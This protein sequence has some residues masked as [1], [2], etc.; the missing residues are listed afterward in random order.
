MF[1]WAY[2]NLILIGELTE[3]MSRREKFNF[4]CLNKKIIVNPAYIKFTGIGKFPFVHTP[5]CDYPYSRHPFVS[6]DFKF[7]NPK[8]QHVTESNIDC[9]YGYDPSTGDTIPVYILV[10]CGKCQP[11]IVKKRVS[12]KNQMILEQSV[13]EEPPVF[14]TLTYDDQ[15]LPHDGVSVRDVQ[16]F[17]K[18]FRSYVDYHYPA[19][20]KFRYVC[21]SEYGSLHGRPHYHLLLFGLGLTSPR[22]ILKLETD[23][24]TTW[25]NG[26]VYAKLC[27]YGCFNYVSKY[28]CKGSN[29]PL[30]KNPNFRLSSRR[31]GGIGVPA[32]D[33][34]SLLSQAIRSP[35]PVIKVKCLGKVFDVYIPKS[36]RDSLF[37]SPRQFYSPVAIK[38]YKRFLH[39]SCLLRALYD[40][41][42]DCAA[43]LVSCANINKPYFKNLVYRDAAIIP[44]EIYD[45]FSPLDCSV[46]KIFVPDYMVVDD[47]DR[48]S[49]SHL[50][51]EYENL[52]EYLLNVVIDFDKMFEHRYLRNKIVG[53]WTLSLVQFSERNPDTDPFSISKFNGIIVESQG[54]KD[55]Q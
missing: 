51:L 32:F 4:M 3:Y 8:H 11:C 30:G 7:F 22:D 53:A 43:H 34:P 49:L 20:A 52:Y 50:L 21:F 9:F 38:R 42:D 48:Q 24:R 45:R 31:H 14:L 15:H 18:R 2:I 39:V 55:F 47:Y 27:D 33:N 41:Y 44:K 28:V 46:Q 25:Q 40:T 19:F 10:E 35:H 37:R 1:P 26:F 23:L 5:D 17:L 54:S 16:L 12:L 13:Q 6:F 36:I 29:V